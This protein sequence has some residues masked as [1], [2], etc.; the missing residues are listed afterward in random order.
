M[1]EFF[2]NV[3]ILVSALLSIAVGYLFDVPPALLWLAAI[4]SA[5]GVAISKPYNPFWGFILIFAGTVAIGQL[6]PIV[7]HYWPSFPQKPVAFFAGLL[8]IGYRQ[9]IK[10]G[11]AKLL[12]AGFVGAEKLITKIFAKAGGDQ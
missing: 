4:G 9:Q 12:T 5:G 7:G 1:Q 8:A 10:E 2:T 3:F 11:A 6:I